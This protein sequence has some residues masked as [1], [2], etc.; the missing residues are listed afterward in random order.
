ME[1]EVVLPNN[2]IFRMFQD[3]YPE[4]PRDWD[5]LGTMACFHRRYTLGDKD[6][7]FSSDDF[8]GWDEMEEYILK[9]LDA[10]VV[11]PLYLYDHSGITMNTT[12]FNCRWDSGQIG[13]IYITKDKI[14]KEYGVKRIRRQL[15]EKVEKMLVNEVEVYDQ[16]LTGDVYGFN[17]VKVTKCDEGHEHETTEDSCSG[18]YGDDIKI[19]GILDHISEEDANVILGEL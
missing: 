13:F 17:I 5:N 3:D 8:N 6:I 12:G 14:M 2:R 9:S 16:Y 19:N 15:K 7:P 1:T 18:F 10:A 4:S 11:L